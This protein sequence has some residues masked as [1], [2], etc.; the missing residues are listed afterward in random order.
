MAG[1]LDTLTEKAKQIYGQ[2]LLNQVI[3]NPASIGQEISQIFDPNY[4]RQ[5][6]PMSQEAALDVALSAPLMAGT[7]R[8]IELDKLAKQKFG[9]TFY[10]AETGFIMDDASRLDFTGRNEASGYRNIANRFIPESGQP[11]YLKM[12]RSSDHRTVSSLIPNENYG[13][14]GLSKFMDETGAVRYDANT[15]VSL[16]NT[17]KP[18]ELQIQKIVD[19]FKKSKTPLIID[20]DK[21]TNGENLASKEFV[22]P[23]ID[24]VKKWID[25]QYKGLLK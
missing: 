20:I 13:W 1:L 24:Q 8:N 17:N 19:D 6:K 9:T 4:M 15:G 16:V 18:N 2:G 11:D 21:T 5:I 3:N 7:L 12:Q 14:G 23:S 25:K 22:N 10:P